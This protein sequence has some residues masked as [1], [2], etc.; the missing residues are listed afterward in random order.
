MDDLTA[1][2]AAQRTFACIATDVGATN[3]F[4]LAVGWKDKDFQG[5]TS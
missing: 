5:A 1:S 2:R 3:I 4:L